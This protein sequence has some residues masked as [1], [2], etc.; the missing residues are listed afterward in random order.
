MIGQI[1]ILLG[2]FLISGAKNGFFY[3]RNN[4]LNFAMI[5]TLL[6]IMSLYT[7]AYSVEWT[8]LPIAAL[9]L[10]QTVVFQTNDGK[11]IHLSEYFVGFA[12]RLPFFFVTD[13]FMILSTILLC[14][15]LF[16]MPI[17]ISVGR[18]LI[19]RFDGTDDPKG[20]YVGTYFLGRFYKVPRL[21]S[22]G[23]TKLY[24]GVAIFTAWVIAYNLGLRFNINHISNY[25][26]LF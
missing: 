21:F 13:I 16:K 9:L 4:N 18:N 25:L 24:V 17:N 3:S 26:D 10:W 22:N 5:M 11:Q 23:Y 14:D 6:V 8:F 20:K 19:E 15:T 1:F 12:L 7:I 2:I